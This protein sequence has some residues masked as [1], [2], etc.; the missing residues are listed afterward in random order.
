MAIV[1]SVWCGQLTIWM[2]K[3]L[4]KHTVSAWPLLAISNNED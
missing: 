3:L 4:S 1:S 2:Q